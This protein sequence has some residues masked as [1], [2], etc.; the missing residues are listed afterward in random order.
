MNLPLPGD[1]PRRATGVLAAV[2]AHVG[3]VAA[4]VAL[5]LAVMGAVTLPDVKTPVAVAAV[6][7]E[8]SEADVE[9]CAAAIAALP[10]L[11]S[12]VAEEAARRCARTPS[13]PLVSLCK[14]AVGF[15]TEVGGQRS[16]FMAIC[17]MLGD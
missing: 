6:P 13:G 16:E 1:E 14:G 5:A 17:D 10:G 9:A 2:V 8:P 12:E 4:G 11:P 15:A 3:A 7:T